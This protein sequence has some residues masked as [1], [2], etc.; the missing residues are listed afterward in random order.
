MRARRRGAV[1]DEPVVDGTVVVELERTDGVGDALDRVRETM[2]EVVHG[3]HIPPLADMVMGDAQDA[4]DHRV[5]QF[6]VGVGHVDL[7]AQGVPTLF[8]L[9][10]LH[11]REQV[12]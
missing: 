6:H 3:V 9:T 10:R 8:K 12:E 2:G 7:G 4:P 1:V 11:P 5:T